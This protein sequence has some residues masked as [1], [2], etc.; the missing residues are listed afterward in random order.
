M[1]NTNPKKIALN[2]TLLITGVFILIYLALSIVFGVF[3]I[4]PFIIL[5]ILLFTMILTPVSLSKA[6]LQ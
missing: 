1:K 2:I 5:P 4:L 3:K 6:R